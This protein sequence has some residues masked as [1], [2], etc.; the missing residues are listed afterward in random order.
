MVYT[1]VRISSKL[2][3]LLPPSPPWESCGLFLSLRGDEQAAAKSDDKFRWNYTDVPF[4]SPP[5]KFR[6]SFC[7]L[8]D[9]RS[10][11]GTGEEKGHSGPQT[12]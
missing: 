12:E 2:T 10:G 11:A 1:T 6:S 7:G 8:W 5:A 3:G 9:Y 4:F